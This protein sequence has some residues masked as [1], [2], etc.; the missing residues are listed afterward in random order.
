M[1]TINNQFKQLLAVI[2]FVTLGFA[3]NNNAQA[4]DEERGFIL[5]IG[6]STIKHGQNTAFT[7]GVK[8]WKAC[9]L[10]NGGDW[11]W[12]MWRRFQ[13]K[14]NVYVLTS[15]VD[16]WA[17]MD[18]DNDEAG[19]KCR[20]ILRDMINPTI[21]SNERKLARFL[22]GWSRS[23][24]DPN[25]VIWVS[26]WQVDNFSLFIETVK[27]IHGVMREVEGDIRGYWYRAIGGGPDSF[28]YFNVTAYPNFAAMDMERD[29]VWTLVEK[30]L[31]EVKKNELQAAF[32]ESVG[33]SWS[34][35][36]TKV[37]ELSHNP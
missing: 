34:Y 5:S 10:E 31:G 2:L 30:K 32:R 36:Y 16:N 11:T 18:E 37:E 33:N 20:H 21:E 17:E 27:T 6:E 35:I 1:K 4:Q 12:N 19:L 3:F 23:T 8:A 29:G 26:N 24:N 7:E 28:D 14:G 22:P 25:N 15:S 13:G 9:Y